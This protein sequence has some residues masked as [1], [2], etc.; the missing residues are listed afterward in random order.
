MQ[1]HDIKKC[2]LVPALALLLG[3]GVYAKHVASAGVVRHDELA[4]AFRL[5]QLDGR[6]RR[7]ADF[8]GKLVVL[9][10]WAGWCPPCRA[11]MPSLWRLKNKMRH[12]PFEIIAL[13]M[14]ER[15]EAIKGFLSKAMQRD[16]VVLLDHDQAVTRR[17]GPRAYPTTYLITAEGRVARVLTGP[18][19]FDHPQ[20]LQLLRSLLPEEKKGKKGHGGRV[21]AI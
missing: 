19:E 3:S 7:L 1:S 6:V 17:Y 5:K 18:F 11:E 14:G 21:N 4:P 16:L 20:M 2:V 13:N 12:E 10:F 8:R 9:N 15:P